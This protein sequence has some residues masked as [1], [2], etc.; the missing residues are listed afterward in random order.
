MMGRMFD[1]IKKIQSN[2][3]QHA[4]DMDD[5]V[6]DLETV[7]MQ[8][9]NTME[10]NLYKISKH[11]NIQEKKSSCKLNKMKISKKGLIISPK[12]SMTLFQEFKNCKNNKKE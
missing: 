4:K 5:M 7:N 12:K 10:D 1:S 3:Q 11:N 8:Y 9:Q 6:I 2:Y